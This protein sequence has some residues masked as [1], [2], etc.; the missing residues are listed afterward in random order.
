MDSGVCGRL[1]LPV[2]PPSSAGRTRSCADGEH[3]RVWNAMWSPLHLVLRCSALCPAATCRI[4]R[5]V[6]RSWPGPLSLGPLVFTSLTPRPVAVER[7]PGENDSGPVLRTLGEAF[8]EKLWVPICQLYEVSMPPHP[9]L[10]LSV[11]VN[12]FSMSVSLSLFRK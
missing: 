10:F 1:H 9:H 11:T 3:P 8:V 12:L 7:R 6:G 5:A 4:W 2:V